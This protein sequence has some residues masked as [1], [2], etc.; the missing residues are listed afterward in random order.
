MPAFLLFDYVNQTY[1]PRLRPYEETEPN[2][3][4][5]DYIASMTDDYFIDLY[6]RLFPDSP[7]QIVYRDYFEETRNR[8]V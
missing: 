6:H 2:Q 4:V 1:Y 3:L 7:Y 8:H 5:V